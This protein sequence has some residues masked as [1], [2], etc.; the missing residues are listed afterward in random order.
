MLGKR[1]KEPVLF[2]VGNVFDLKLDPRSFHAQL[3]QAAPELF[4]DETFAELYSGTVG[5][6]SVPPSQMALLMILQTAAGVSDQEAVNLSAFDLRWCA[7]LRRSAG[8]PLCART[9]LVGFRA[10]LALKDVAERLF[11]T[12]IEEARRRGL[13][14]GEPLKLLLDTKPMLGR[15]AVEDTYN[16]IARSMDRLIRALAQ[17]AGVEVAA[18][19]EQH[20][21][22]EYVRQRESSLKGAADIDWSDPRERQKFLQRLVQAARRLLQLTETALLPTLSAPAE[23]AIRKEYQLLQTILAQDVEERPGPQHQPSGEPQCGL[24]EE[25]QVELKEE[26][27]VELPEEP[28]VELKEGTDRDRVPSVTD[29]EQRH[30][31]KS[32]SHKFNGH[33]VR[34]AVDSDSQL[35]VDVEVLAGNAADAVAAL[36]QVKRA[37]ARTGLAVESTTGDCAYG[38]GATRQEFAD[39]NRTL[40]AKVPASRNGNLL[41]KSRFTLIFAGTEVVEVQCPDG[42]STQDWKRKSGGGRVFTFGA[43]CRRCPLRHV[44]LQNLGKSRSIHIHPQEHLLHEAQAFQASEDGRRTLRQRVGVEHALARLAQ[45]G[46]GQ[47][48]YFGRQKAKVQLLLAATV[49]NLRLTW[50]RTEAAGGGSASAGSRPGGPTGANSRLQGHSGAQFGLLRRLGHLL[51]ALAPLK[52]HRRPE[53]A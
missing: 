28:Q 5:R 45:L 19:A 41:P 17:Q 6:P 14:D 43:Y 8:T 13:L 48:R 35:I 36:E 1:T 18:W 27:Q 33:K 42:R 23:A 12:S 46:I 22:K 7:V 31:R 21:L 32:R 38:S 15:G 26:P 24:P 50:N 10:K 44:C 40:Y 34:V 52:L 49:A 30:G 11:D 9:T 39:A 3:A 51:H 53:P 2:D 20:E 25:P 29:D 4:K 16:L 47:A 37:E